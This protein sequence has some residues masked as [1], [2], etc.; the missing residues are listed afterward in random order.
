[1]VFIPTR[2]KKS[3]YGN[4]ITKIG[5]HAF[6]SRKEASWYLY[7]RDLEQKGEIHDLRTQVEFEILPAIYETQVIHL[8]TKDKSVQKCVQSAVHY[9]ADFTY[10]DA[11]GN[12]VV[13]DVK[14][15]A[16]RKD[17]VYVLKKKMMR[18]LLGITIVEK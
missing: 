2:T 16:T 12:L 13:V 7:F 10:K 6:D 11:Y 4:I 1:M 5:D 3:K 14:S 18:A 9:I 8:K 17:K 15:E